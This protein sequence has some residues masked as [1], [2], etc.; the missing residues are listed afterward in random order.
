MPESIGRA[1]LCGLNLAAETRGYLPKE[2]R[3]DKNYSEAV[4]KEKSIRNPATVFLRRERQR[5]LTALSEKPKKAI[6]KSNSRK[7]HDSQF[8]TEQT[9][10]FPVEP[11]LVFLI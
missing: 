2:W 5:N 11:K 4:L 8:P 9:H 10:P 6:A 7:T 3:I 1:T